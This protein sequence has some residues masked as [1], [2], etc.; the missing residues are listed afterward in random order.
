V[1][2]L[3]GLVVAVGFSGHGFKMAASLGAVAAELIAEGTSATD[4]SF[5]DPG[6]FLDPQRAVAA[7]PRDGVATYSELL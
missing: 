7:W 3:D 1:P 2:G 6:R 5:M 4:V